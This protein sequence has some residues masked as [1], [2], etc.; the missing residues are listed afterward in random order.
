MIFTLSKQNKKQVLNLV[1]FIGIVATCVFGFYYFFLYS[2]SFTFFSPVE[3]RMVQVYYGN[4]ELD[5]EL[6]CD[7]VF[8]VERKVSLTVNPELAALEA[9]LLGPTADE[10]K[11]GYFTSIN[12][13][14]Y[15][16]SLDVVNAIAYVDLSEELN[17]N[18]AGACRVT[19]IRAEIAMTLK[20]FREI[21][22]VIISVKG[23]RE[24]ILQP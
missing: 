20:Q 7:K 14:V 24:T 21:E 12:S 19:A 4:G 11:N 2:S 6:S 3:G 16:T 17:K 1:A 8:P 9:Q 22:D 13:G 5:P 10:K 15:V 18:V 23:N